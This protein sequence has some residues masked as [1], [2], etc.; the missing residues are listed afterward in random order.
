MENKENAQQFPV[1]KGL[2]KPFV[3]KG[4]KGKFIYYAGGGL[5]LSLIIGAIGTS[6]NIIF[7]LIAMIIGVAFTIFYVN[8]LQKTKG[9]FNKTKQ[10]NILWLHDNK[11]KLFKN[12]NEKG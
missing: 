11:I 3:F 12:Q 7:G 9:L 5:L 8:H 4:Y 10:N 6:F 1:Y 2:K